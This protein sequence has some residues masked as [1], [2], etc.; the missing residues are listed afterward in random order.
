[1]AG[2]S[3]KVVRH[4]PRSRRHGKTMRSEP[5]VRFPGCHRGCA[6]VQLRLNGAMFQVMVAPFVCLKCL[7][8][9]RRCEGSASAKVVRHS[10]RSRWHHWCKLNRTCDFPVVIADAPCWRIHILKACLKIGSCGRDQFLCVGLA[11][12]CG[13]LKAAGLG[14]LAERDWQ[15]RGVSGTVW[16]RNLWHKNPG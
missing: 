11:K 16:D 14:C 13:G 8:R 10:P 6:G 1:L 4:S 5:D 9:H 2:A 3:A 7:E 15:G 12:S